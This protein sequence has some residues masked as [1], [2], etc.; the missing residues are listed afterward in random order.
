MVEF[1]IIQTAEQIGCEM[2][3]EGENIRVMNIDFLP[4]LLKLKIREHKRQILDI[5]N[6]DAQAKKA[7]LV[8]GLTGQVYFC[9][10][11]SKSAV[12]MEQTN[13]HWELWRETYHD[14]R[15]HS[16]SI[17]VICIDSEFDKTILRAKGYF[18]S[19]EKELMSL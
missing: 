15:R 1:E 19:V 8:I 13:G 5:L 10:I 11:N 18:A 16:A 17:Q 12:Y 2:M 14:G 3:P 4:A 7:G 6:R 9:S